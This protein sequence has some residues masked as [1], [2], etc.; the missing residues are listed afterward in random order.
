M[1]LPAIRIAYDFSGMGK[2]VKRAID[3]LEAVGLGD[4][5]DTTACV[6]GFERRTCG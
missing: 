4:D 2:Y 6:A 1:K 5:T 3:L